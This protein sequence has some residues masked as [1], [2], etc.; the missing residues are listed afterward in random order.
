MTSQTLWDI[1]L[2]ERRNI[3]KNV[4]EG[5]SD[6]TNIAS[7]SHLL[8]CGSKDAGKTSL[9]QR[10]L[11]RDETPKPTVGLDFC[12][13]R[14]S[15]QNNM[16]QVKDVAQIW[17]LGGGSS[18]SKLLDVVITPSNIRKLS[19]V[20]VLDLS[21]PDQLWETQETLLNQIKQRIKQV[22]TEASKT[23]TNIEN[24]LKDRAWRR[25]GKN[26]TDKNTITPLLVPLVII[27]AKSD[28]Y[29]DL[30][31]DKKE[32]LSKTIRFLAL[33]NGGMIQFFSTKAEGLTSRAKNVLNHLAF[34]SNLSK[35]S[36]IE[37]TK[38]II[39]PYGMDTLQQI[40]APPISADRLV[41]ARR[42]GL[43]YDLW[44]DTYLSVFPSQKEVKDEKKNPATDKQ[45]ADEI[46]DTIRV[47]KD[48]ELERYRKVSARKA[49][50]AQLNA[51]VGTKQKKK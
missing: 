45:F 17:E 25:V 44:S 31:S 13:G 40:G 15:K 32:M 47:Q 46:V 6:S 14:K 20:L 38:P 28:L 18:M 33:L 9:I 11:E 23:D 10:F 51:S 49:K 2:N 42:G 41:K 19:V 50:E 12:Y 27:G 22:I 29:Q 7:E 1:A 37:H 26:H 8:V 36:C 30:S 39:V 48:E 16:S 34:A 4:S 35:T 24:D 3:L 5:H 43:P 21:K